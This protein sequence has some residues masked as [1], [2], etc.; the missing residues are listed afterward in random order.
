MHRMNIE[1][2]LPMNVLESLVFRVSVDAD[3]DAFAVAE[4]KIDGKDWKILVE[5]CEDWDDGSEDSGSA[6]FFKRK[7]VS[8]DMCFVKGRRPQTLVAL[9]RA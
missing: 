4:V 9:Q 8:G 3:G 6:A 1:F 2:E 5:D 7:A